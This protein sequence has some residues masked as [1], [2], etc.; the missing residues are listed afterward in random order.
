MGVCVKENGR[1]YYLV[2]VEMQNKGAYTVIRSGN[3][4]FLKVT[5]PLTSNDDISDVAKGI[6]RTCKE[7]RIK[8]SRKVFQR[9][10]ERGIKELGY[11][12]KGLLEDSPPFTLKKIVLG[13]TPLYHLPQ[14]IEPEFLKILII[15]TLKRSRVEPILPKV[16]EKIK[17]DEK[18]LKEFLGGVLQS[19]ATEVVEGIVK[20]IVYLSIWRYGEDFMETF[21]QFK[22]K[23][24]PAT[25]FQTVERILVFLGL[26]RWQISNA[27]SGLFPERTK[28]NPKDYIR[29]YETLREVA[30][31]LGIPLREAFAFYELGG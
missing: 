10:L 26:R 12:F 20:S 24:P 13:T 7:G 11:K 30:L 21:N 1:I 19:I 6:I 17:N 28:R 16:E 31:D 18:K 22:F 23:R 4:C 3:G 5:K 14:L 15:R 25:F 29:W 8:E 9:A 2:S 27:R